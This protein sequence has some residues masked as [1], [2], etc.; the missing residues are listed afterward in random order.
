MSI[1]TDEGYESRR[2]YLTSLADDF[3]V[4]VDTVFSIASILGSAEDFDG[5]ICELEDYQ[6]IGIL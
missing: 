3:G 1:Y 5:L 2:D 6:S 4:D